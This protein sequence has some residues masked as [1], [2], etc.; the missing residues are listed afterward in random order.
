MSE[1]KSQWL[2]Q[3]GIKPRD[4]DPYILG[5]ENSNLHIA[6]FELTAFVIFKGIL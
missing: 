3:K 6:P 4:I 1:D 2:Q 5:Q